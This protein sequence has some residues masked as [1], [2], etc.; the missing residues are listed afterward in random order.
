[1]R[2]ILFILL[3]L[4]FSN[5]SFSQVQRDIEGKSLIRYQIM[6]NQEFHFYRDWSTVAT[7][8]SGIGETV[9]LFPI[10]FN[11]PDNKTFLQGLQL[12]AE[13][14]PQQTGTV[15]RNASSIVGGL[16]NKDFMKRSVFLDK[17]DVIKMAAYIERDIIPNLKTTYK[18]QSKEYVFKSN[19]M[20]FSFLIDEK[21]ARITIHIADYG[22]LNN[23]Q[24]GGDQIEFWTESKIDEIPSFLSTLKLFIKQMK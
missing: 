3:S 10:T 20:F 19:E 13:V 5:I 4:V 17:E 9:K 21:D 23:G 1:M 12:D 14:K 22:P 18:K 15:V 2:K 24:G 8:K 6:Q 11:T 7:F 16:I